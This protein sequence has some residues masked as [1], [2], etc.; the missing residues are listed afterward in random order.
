MPNAHIG[1]NWNSFPLQISLHFAFF[2]SSW[3]RSS[4]SA[5]RSVYT[6]LYAVL[7][8]IRNVLTIL[9]WAEMLRILNIVSLL[10][11]FSLS[12][13]VFSSAS[14]QSINTHMIASLLIASELWAYRITNHRRETSSSPSQ[15]SLGE[16][17]PS[18]LPI[19]CC[20]FIFELHTLRA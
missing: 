15:A 10:S 3:V 14:T 5:N 4:C 18:T 1:S 9:L 16:G 6:S 7:V 19:S 20:L 11:S 13:H 2:L 12:F 17:N 8:F